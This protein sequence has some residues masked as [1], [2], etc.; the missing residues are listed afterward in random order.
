LEHL[1][2]RWGASTWAGVTDGLWST[3]SN[4]DAAPTPGA[5]L[6]FP[7]GASNLANLNDLAAGQSYG[8]FT[9][10]GGGYS[11]SGNEI[12]LG[13]PITA[14]YAAGS[15]T[16]ALPISLQNSLVVNVAGAA[17]T[18]NLNGV[19]SG[20][21]GLAKL[22][23]G[24]LVLGGDN[25]YTGD[26]N[27]SGGTLLVRGSQGGSFVNV[28]S[29]AKLSGTGVVGGAQ[30][31]GGTLGATDGGTSLLTVNGAMVLDSASTFEVVLN[32]LTPGTEYS[33]VQVSGPIDL[34]GAALDVTLG[35]APT[36]HAQF[37]IINN[38]GSGAVSGTFAGLPEGSQVVVGAHTFR[39]DY[40]GGDGND[41]ELTRQV[42]TTTTLT[43]VPSA[44]VYGQQVSLTATVSA[45]ESTGQDPTGN[46]TFFAG[47]T[48][49]G[50]AP[51]AGGVAQLDTSA[52][53]LGESLVTAVYAGDAL[54]LGSTSAPEAV[55]VGQAATITSLTAVPA[56]TVTGQ[57]IVLTAAVSVASPG[58]GVPAG[59]VE[60]FADGSSLGFAGLVGGVASLGT[61]S[62]N[63]GSHLLT[64]EYLGGVE[65][66]GS[67]SDGVPVSVSEAATT[68][69]LTAAPNPV[70]EGQLV[71]LTA[72]VSAI[73]PGSGIPTGFV[74][75][76]NGGTSLGTVPLTGGFAQLGTTALPLADNVITA[77]YLGDG[78]YEA[79]VSEPVVVTVRLASS[80]GL[81]VSPNAI[82][83]GESVTLTATVTDP[84]PMSGV[85]TGQVE[86]YV[87]TTLLGSATL[88]GGVAVLGTTALP[89]G[90]PVVVA[91]YLGDEDYASSE[92]AGE[93]VEVSQAATAT[94]LS[95]VPSTAV[96]GQSVILTADLTVMPPGAGVPTGNVEFFIGMASLGQAPLVNGSA[97]L[98]VTS[99]P[100][101]SS[102]ITARYLGDANFLS[103][104]SNE[105]EVD[106]S[107][108]ATATSLAADPTSVVVGQEVS[109]VASVI[110]ISPGM[111]TPTGTVE[112]YFNGTELLGQ[113]E[114]MGGLAT[115]ITT[116][117]PVGVP[118]VTAR[119]LGSAANIASESEPVGVTVEQAATTTS[120]TTSPNPSALGQAVQ[121][122]AIVAV[123][124]PGSGQPTG[125]VEFFAGMTSLGFADVNSSGQAVLSTSSLALGTQILTARYLGDSSFLASTSD[126]VSQIVERVGTATTLSVSDSN[127]DAFEPV[128][129][130]AM[131][132]PL[133]GAT[134]PDGQVKFVLNGEVIGTANLVDGKAVFTT[135]A[136]PIGVQS[137]TAQYV[138]DE[139]FA[140][141]ESTP[142]SVTVG[143]ANERY[144]NAVYLDL[145]GR[146]ATPKELGFWA[147]R[148][149]RGGSRTAFTLWLINS[150]D[151]R[152]FQ[153][154]QA[155]QQYLGRS[156]TRA[157]VICTITR[158]FD[159]GTNIPGVV[160]STQAYFREV[161]GGT[162]NGY[163]NALAEDVLGQPFSAAMQAH[164]TRA[165]REGTPL[166]EVVL[167][168]FG[169]RQGRQAQVTQ[170]IQT[171][172]GRDPE[173]GEV[174]NLQR[175]HGD[176]T[177]QRQIQAVLYASDEYYED[178]TGVLPE[179]VNPAVVRIVKRR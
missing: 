141:S 158:A 43:A 163:L 179:L 38:L 169:T 100:V 33:Q 125:Q 72:T 6:V 126:P 71:Q 85:P 21:S 138:G 29:G 134:Q 54:F 161:G 34:G 121:L 176:Q 165:I 78:S 90:N 27:V 114:L 69:F 156:A 103:S 73:A 139:E 166:W 150:H 2:G 9:V 59:L 63:V 94:V 30:V 55:Q 108:A 96:F 23:G 95:A 45:V 48:N 66:L 40:T 36:G 168:V 86:F 123:T 127:P 157:E 154:Q 62:L 68:T 11:I 110:V 146:A 91:R 131:V 65:H 140:P 31:A 129:F 58:G 164:L 153:V 167:A 7:D 16:V 92:S 57:T 20:T 22:G 116:Q 76:F 119:Y 49:L 102:V 64:A 115:L 83:H 172:L 124:S 162:I 28:G 97:E 52:L 41:V 178:A 77:S 60:F 42:G 80:T 87:G 14:S 128:T 79:S 106:V 149:D 147:S 130:T 50:S 135:G 132:M 12:A 113:A 173:S 170:S 56:A 37:V 101:G 82:T 24:T 122:T 118:S 145:T 32:G 117:L 142:V 120:L 88:S 160:L 107:A 70:A 152:A 143:T 26:T 133:V 47:S 75:F 171:I 19:I 1:E 10:A 67:T 137:V 105:V 53:P 35:F 93:T 3:G 136:L 177:K 74:E 175:L 148:L 99:L 89:A 25:A 111:G 109:L 155:Y 17:A 46:V 144:V 159:K 5:D 81:S 61:G 15:S 39:I 51:V 44:A 8:S 151:S 112:F 4:W 84:D 104:L 18:L 174:Q 13:G 98:E